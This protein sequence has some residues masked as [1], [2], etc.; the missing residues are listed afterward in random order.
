MLETIILFSLTYVWYIVVVSFLFFCWLIEDK[1]NELLSTFYTIACLIGAYWVL[2]TLWLY[3]AYPFV[4]VI[5]S[6]F[7]YDN[8]CA[9]M[10]HIHIMNNEQ[11]LISIDFAYNAGK[12]SNWVINWPLSFVKWV[13]ADTVTFIVTKFVNVSRVFYKKIGERHL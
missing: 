7:K 6:L 3:A 9:K 13:I 2:P 12:L 4:G 10:R 8:L 5:W 11:Y 1:K